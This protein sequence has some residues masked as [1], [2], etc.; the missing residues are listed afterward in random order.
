MDFGCIFGNGCSLLF[1]GSHLFRLVGSSRRRHQTHGRNCR[2]YFVD[3]HGIVLHDWNVSLLHINSKDNQISSEHGQIRIL[4]Y[5][6]VL[7][8]HC[9]VCPSIN[10]ICLLLFYWSIWLCSCP[11]SDCLHADGGGFVSVCSCHTP[12]RLSFSLSFFLFKKKSSIKIYSC[13]FVKMPLQVLTDFFRYW[14]GENIFFDSDK[15]ILL[16]AT[17]VIGVMA[18]ITTFGLMVNFAAANNEK[19]AT[20]EFTVGYQSHCWWNHFIS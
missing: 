17:F 2:F 4:R 6:V 20:Y 7:L 15:K 19:K 18:I 8:R 16:W 13:F 5:V 11:L 10:N 1:H 14:W 9:S 12:G 3:R